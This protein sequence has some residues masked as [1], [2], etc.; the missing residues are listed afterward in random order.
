[1]ISPFAAHRLAGA[2]GNGAGGRIAA[3]P[4]DGHGAVVPAVGVGGGAVDK[5]NGRQG[6]IAFDDD[7]LAAAA[8]A[9]GGGAGDGVATGVGVDSHRGAAAL[10]ADG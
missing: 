1:M 4:V 2:G 6:G 3:T 8:T 10:V 7:A 5:G 9:A